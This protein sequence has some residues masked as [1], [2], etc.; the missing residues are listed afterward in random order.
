MSVARVL[1][2]IQREV[3]VMAKVIHV[4]N[5]ELLSRRESLLRE[6]GTSWDS[7]RVRAQRGEL[8]DADWRFREDL[9][10]ISYLLGESEQID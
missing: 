8:G 7:Y 9:D 3:A 2:S 1:I 5:G 10:A 4:S 6:I